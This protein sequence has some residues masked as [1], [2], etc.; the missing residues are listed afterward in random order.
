MLGCNAGLD[1][2]WRRQNVVD[3]FLCRNVFHGNF[4]FRKV[5]NQRLHD[6]LDE[7]RLSFKDISM[8]HF[9][10]DAKHHSGL[11]HGLENWIEILD[12]GHTQ[13]RIGSGSSRIVL[14]PDNSR[15]SIFVLEGGSLFDFIGAGL[16]R[17][18]ECHE[19]LEGVVGRI[20]WHAG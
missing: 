12:V 3:R 2:V 1:I 13:I 15:S 20:L 16:V 10:V 4:E 11:L 6:F 19:G 8:R 18:V 5:P 17:Q 7:Y 14:A 9:R